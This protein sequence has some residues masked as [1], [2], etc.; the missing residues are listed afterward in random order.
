MNKIPKFT[1][2]DEVNWHICY[3]ASD[4]KEDSENRAWWLEELIEWYTMYDNALEKWIL[5]EKAKETFSSA[6]KAI[7]ELINEALFKNDY[8]F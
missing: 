7:L 3:L 6:R 2:Y 5:S 1:L 4:A 8:K